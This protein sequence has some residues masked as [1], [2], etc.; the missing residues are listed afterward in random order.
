MKRDLLYENLIRPILFSLDPESVHYFAAASLLNGKMFLPAMNLTYRKDDLQTDLFGSTLANP[1]G[2]A[3]GFDKNG[4]LAPV[5]GML[6]FAYAEIGSVCGRPHGGN[7]RPRLFRLPED[8]ALINRLGLNG[9]GAEV[10]ATNLQRFFADSSHAKPDSILPIGINIAKTNDARLVGDEAVQD[11]VYSFERLKDLPA[12]Y[13]TINT[14]CPNTDEGCLKESEF[15]EKTLARIVESNSK[16]VP[17]LVKL[18]PDSTDEFNEELVR[19]ATQ[20]KV[21]GFVCGNT[22]LRRDVLRATDPTRF[23]AIGNGGLSGKPLKALNLALTAKVARLKKADQIIIGVG[24]IECGEDVFDYI[25]AGAHLVQI[26]TGF[27][28]RGPG[29]VKRISEELSE[30]LKSKGITLQ[31][32]RT[33]LTEGA[34]PLRS[35]KDGIP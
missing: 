26:Y 13:F 23:E 3:A 4:V 24:G 8:K 17:V 33:A 19:L 18:S 31:Q 15:L 34:L 21:A 16:N 32:L 6:G 9:L 20:H 35:V 27:V 14:S 11:M 29:A 28:Y 30:I 10:V 25:K 12:K 7:L 1:I 22:T 2:L 5:L